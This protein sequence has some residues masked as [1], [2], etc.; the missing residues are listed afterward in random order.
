MKKVLISLVALTAFNASAGMESSSK[1][2]FAGDSE[3]SSFCKAVVND[4]LGML[5]RSLRS[6]VGQVAASSNDV[7]RKL[8]SAEGMKCNG[9]DLIQFSEQ[10]E[11]S[12][13]SAYLKTKNNA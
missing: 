1:V 11:A 8:V 10:R 12:Q 2:R 13:V 5:K 6:K 3:Y 4:D 9:V 7:L